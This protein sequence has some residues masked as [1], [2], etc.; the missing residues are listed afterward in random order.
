MESLERIS[1]STVPNGKV[2]VNARLSKDGTEIGKFSAT[3]AN[4]MIALSLVS[5]W[6]EQG[7]VH[8]DYKPNTM[9][10]GG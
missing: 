3:V 7:S 5:S 6:Q 10:N 4:N 2:L 9:S 8:P 1:I